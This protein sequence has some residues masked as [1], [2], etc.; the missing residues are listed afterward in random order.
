MSTVTIVQ[1]HKFH[2]EI[3]KGRIT[4]E[5]LQNFL[6]NPSGFVKVGQ[7]PSLTLAANLIP[8]GWTI[9]EDVVPSIKNGRDFITFLEK[10]ES[11]ING[12]VMRKRAKKLTANLGLVDA[13]NDLEHQDNIPVGLR[14]KYLVYSGTVL[15][16]SGG[17]L[18]VPCL[19]W[20]GDRWVLRF[21]WLGSDFHGFGRLARGK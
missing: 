13:K 18:S 9:I 1:L 6:E 14:G 8:T 17:R 10:G 16:V 21:D 11:Y 5:L 19:F 15:R 20:Y 3:S 12:E 4:R 7:F 2:D